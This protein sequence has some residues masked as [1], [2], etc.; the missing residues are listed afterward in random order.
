MSWHTILYCRSI[1]FSTM[2]QHC[3]LLFVSCSVVEVLQDLLYYLLY[4]NYSVA[5]VA[6][7]KKS[8]MVCVV[9]AIP[10]VILN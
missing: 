8:G 9:L 10:C 1:F 7:M 4:P 3:L 2:H 5:L 6:S